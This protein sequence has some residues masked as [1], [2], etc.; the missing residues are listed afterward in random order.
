MLIHKA[1]DG[2]KVSLR[3]KDPKY[4]VSP[5]ASSFGGGGHLMAAGVTLNVPDFQTAEKVMLPKVSELLGEC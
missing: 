5:I 2:F 3:S 1:P 4:P